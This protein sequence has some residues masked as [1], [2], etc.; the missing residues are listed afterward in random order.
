MMRQA[1]AQ[2]VAWQARFPDLHLHLNLSAR[3]FLHPDLVGLVSETMQRSG[4]NSRHLTLE[5]SEGTLLGPHGTQDILTRLRAL[6]LRLEIDDFGTGYSSLAYLQQFPIQGLKIDRSFTEG[7]HEE[8]GQIDL[9][10]TDA[11]IV[12]SLIGLA[13]S[14]GLTTVAEGIETRAQAQALMMMGCDSL[15]GYLFF[16]PL[17]AEELTAFQSGSGWV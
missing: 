10:C 8:D 14:L 6:G 3:Q 15:Q 13:Q 11:K 7:L 1:M 12:R 2:A 16:R 5:I 4:L 17:T 9:D